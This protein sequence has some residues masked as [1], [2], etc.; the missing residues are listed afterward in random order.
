VVVKKEPTFA[1]TPDR[2]KRNGKS[3]LTVE[4]MGKRIRHANL[5]TSNP[6]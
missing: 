6:V 2:A 3:T 1:A 4:A 5:L